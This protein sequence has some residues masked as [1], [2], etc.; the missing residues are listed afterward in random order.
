MIE[1]LKIKN[2]KGI[3]DV[4]FDKFGI[5]NSV[6][7]KN[8]CGK[9]SI[10]DCI[11]WLIT[12]A[13]LTFGD[14]NVDDKCINQNSPNELIE[15]SLV[16]N[17]NEISRLY[18]HKLLDNNNIVDVNYFYTNGRKCKSKK[19]YDE[20]VNSYLGINIT[21][22][23]K[24]NLKYALINPYFFGREINQEVFRRF[25]M[26][27][28]NVD[29]ND[30]VF[31]QDTDNKFAVIKNDY[32]LQG[33]DDNNLK[34]FYKQKITECN[35]KIEEVDIKLST[36]TADNVDINQ[37]SKLEKLIEEKAKYKVENQVSYTNSKIEEIAK[38][39]TD[40]L[41]ELAKSQS[42]DL[43]NNV[44][45]EEKKLGKEINDLKTTI[46]GNIDKYNMSNMVGVVEA[47]ITTCKMIIEQKKKDIESVENSKFVVIE[48]PNCHTK[49]NEE[50]EKTFNF[51]KAEK[52]KSLNTS[53][54]E[55]EKKLNDLLKEKED[56]DK[57]LN[58]LIEV[59][60]ADKEK[61]AS[62]NS[63]LSAIQSNKD[64]NIDSEKTT[65]L[66]EKLSALN[67]ELEQEQY[68]LNAE[69]AELKE[70]SR[71]KIEEFDTQINN[72]RIRLEK[73]NEYNR[74][75]E[76]KIELVA[77]K[78]DYE[79]KHTLTKELSKK[80]SKITQEFTKKIFGDDVEFVMLKKNKTNE[81]YKRTC[82]AQVKGVSY[83][84][85]NTANALLTGI[86]VSEKIK[87]FLNLKDIP[88]VFD[89]IDNIGESVLKE[90]QSKTNSQIFFTQVD[91]TDKEE[92][93][94]KV[95]K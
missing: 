93:Q 87:A 76:S 70:K 20:L 5:I 94:L 33:N 95:I 92:R 26:Q 81:D 10:L 14:G 46:N 84:S 2:F 7:G 21:T 29:F 15:A 23:E 3:R 58:D 45:E 36:Y 12:G 54:S 56:N 6:Y 28:L 90:I 48:C 37:E 71:I 17:G 4:E 24:I 77:S 25:I 73:V 80:I 64:K 72:E 50:E 55:E 11:L 22:K 67:N 79:T 74:L 52:L 19:E 85:L 49:L 82:Y 16:I 66:K 63:D 69:N 1:K 31:Q 34:S 68:N 18:G 61:L 47:K 62:K 86:I 13:T 39:I 44:S 43:I 35:N 42:N 60:K 57:E 53:L 91:R 51:N 65:A 78:L 41:L 9:T 75:K 30:I 32:K 59:I 40:T 38:S 88:I 89:I 27:I 83:D 8:G